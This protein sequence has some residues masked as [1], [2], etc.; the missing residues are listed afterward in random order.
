MTAE[1]T[2]IVLKIQ[3]RSAAISLVAS[4]PESDAER[5]RIE[6][7]GDFCIDAVQERKTELLDALA[8]GREL[9]LDLGGVSRIDTA[10]LQLLT[11]LV[12]ELGQQG[13][14]VHFC[15]VSAQVTEAARVTGL[16]SILGLE[17]KSR[18]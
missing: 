7:R 15:E 8:I 17:P 5:T 12:L 10:G 4:Q 6:W 2:A 14:I 3:P 1:D 9:E 18:P 16:S 11:A 13:R